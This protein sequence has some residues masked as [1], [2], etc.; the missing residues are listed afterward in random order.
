MIVRVVG[1]H[2]VQTELFD[3]VVVHRHTD[4]T[5]G[6][7]CHEVD[8]LRGGVLRRTDQV[9]LILT[10]GIVDHED[11]LAGTQGFQCLG[12]GVIIQDSGSPFSPADHWP[13]PSPLFP[14][15]THRTLTNRKITSL[16]TVSVWFKI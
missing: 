13:F 2:L 7:A 12:Y 1:D 14:I 5:L 11:Q 15:Q 16:P 8:I 3:V 6:V 4:Q 9:A 10:V